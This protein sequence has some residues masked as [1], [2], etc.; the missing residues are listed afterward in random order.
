VSASCSLFSLSFPLFLNHIY[1]EII[2]L[3]GEVPDIYVEVIF[4]YG[5]VSDIYGYVFDIYGE[6][7]FLSV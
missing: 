2:F 1:G 7:F 5:D 4:L 6:V 3:C